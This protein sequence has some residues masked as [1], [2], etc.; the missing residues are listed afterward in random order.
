MYYKFC[1][2]NEGSMLN[3]G[4]YNDCYL[5]SPVQT[6]AIRLKDSGR[7][8]TPIGEQISAHEA[9]LV[10][11]TTEVRALKCCST[12]LSNCWYARNVLCV[13]WVARQSF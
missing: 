4:A 3:Q 5:I 12:F 7:D 8:H 1:Y 6:D 2:V 9:S 11:D 13:D 10:R